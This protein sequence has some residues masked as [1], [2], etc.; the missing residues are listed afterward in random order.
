MPVPGTAFPQRKGKEGIE[1]GMS[2]N[3]I[4]VSGGIGKEE[5]GNARITRADPDALGPGF[6]CGG[7]DLEVISCYRRKP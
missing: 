1:G 3:E 2:K 5:M 4:P 6:L 7:A